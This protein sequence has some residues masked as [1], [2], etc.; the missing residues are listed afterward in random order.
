VKRKRERNALRSRILSGKERQKNMYL[1]GARLKEAARLRR[2]SLKEIQEQSGIRKGDIDYYWNNPVTAISQEHLDAFVK[3][4]G[5]KPDLL[6]VKGQPKVVALRS[7]K[8]STEDD[9]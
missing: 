8:F 9:S 6:L 2:L 3:L 1:N 5:I 4:L 7:D